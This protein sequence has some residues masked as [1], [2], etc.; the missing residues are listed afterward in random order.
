MLRFILGVSIALFALAVP[1]RAADRPN[2]LIILLDDSDYEY[3][4][5]LGHPAAYTPNLDRILADGCIFRLGYTMPVC[6]PAIAS[7]ISGQYPDEH[8]IRNNDSLNRLS[9]S[10]SLPAMLKNAGYNTFIGGKFWERTDG[11][12][13]PRPYGFCVSERISGDGHGRFVRDGQEGFLAFIDNQARLAQPW[14]ALYA[15]LLP[16]LP[17]YDCP[18]EFR[19]RINPAF[20]PIPSWISPDE[21]SAFR[22]DVHLYL[23]NL[24][25]LDF[26]LGEVLARLDSAGVRHD[27][28]IV[29]LADNG[30][31][32]DLVSKQSPFEKGLRTHI[33][34]TYPGRIAPAQRDHLVS[35]VDVAPTALHYAGVP[36]PRTYSGISLRPT[37]DLGLPT[38]ELLFANTYAYGS[39][40]GVAGPNPRVS[41]VARDQRYKYIR[42]DLPIHAVFQPNLHWATNYAPFPVYPE[43]TELLFDLVADPYEQTDLANR[44]SHRPTL[45]SL[46]A[47]AHAWNSRR[48]T[49]APATP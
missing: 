11:V 15:P 29:T 42:F 19:A 37:I 34:F 20:I 24:A 16:H 47:A 26:A 28:L 43:G 46:R 38:R 17:T 12:V 27:T 4:A 45:L 22:N 49:P 3:P 36:I 44:L 18:L 23:A 31:S 13:D 30:W 6:R 48:R 35:L 39:I 41:T 8:E 5:H 7:L 32:Y 1:S 21:A 40:I 2:I 10:H 14:F 33:S 25:W 9:P